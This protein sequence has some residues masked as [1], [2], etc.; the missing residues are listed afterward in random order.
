MNITGDAVYHLLSRAFDDVTYGP[1]G[2]RA[3]SLTIDYP[4]LYD[5][6]ANMSGHAVL[7]PDHERPEKGPLFRDVLAICSSATLASWFCE[8]DIPYVCV[9]G[10]TFPQLYNHMQRDA[11]AHERLD[12]QL[13]AHLESYA[14]FHPL[15]DAITD[16]FG[17]SCTLLDKDYR[18]V[19]YSVGHDLLDKTGSVLSDA[20][21][22]E[23]EN[24]DLFM[25]S[26]EYGSLR[27]T[28]KVFF[29][30]G[31][32]SLLARNVFYHDDLVGTL[33]MVHDGET[34][35]ARFVR[36][37]LNYLAPF[38]EQMY[39]RL[40]SFAREFTK[41]DSIRNSLVSL[42]SGGRVDTANI[43]RLLARGGHSQGVRYTLLLID[44]SFSHEGVEGLHY[45]VRRISQSWRRSYAFVAEEELYVLIYMGDSEGAHAQALRTDIPEL[46]R[47][48]MAKAGVSRLFTSASSLEAA[49]F[50]ARAALEQG[51]ADNPTFWYYHFEDYA[52][53]WLLAH[54]VGNTPVE[55]VCHP[56]VTQLLRYDEETGS[57]LL[58]TLEMFMRCR[59]NAS[60]AA[61]QLFVARSTLLARL[62]RI[63][64]LTGVNLE[65]L[66]ERTY[67]ALSLQL[68][69]RTQ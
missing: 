60:M 61:Q 32:S 21:M 26:D 66:E 40:G 23:E 69:A 27:T 58:K 68:C 3:L 4:I 37:L 53:P 63:E 29:P 31:S 6:A 50:Q 20:S 16:T 24:A 7:V 42:F 47:D 56:A 52:L 11:V 18:R 35:T 44:R 65:R 34:G 33:L 48:V 5:A 45:L 39:N 22:F 54:G 17:C 38:V 10:V 9:G 36:F 59:Y 1:Q 43:D 28:R 13:K 67:L 55:Y 14:G 2:S 62:E 15:L 51:N 8:R 46:L 41:A 30:P 19:C 64:E 25:A 49:R 12:A 57:S